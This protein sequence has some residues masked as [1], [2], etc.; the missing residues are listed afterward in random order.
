MGGGRV[1]IHAWI[2]VGVPSAASLGRPSF[3]WASPTRCCLQAASSRSTCSSTTGGASGLLERLGLRVSRLDC[4]EHAFAPPAD[5]ASRWSWLT[6]FVA[7]RKPRIQCGRD[8]V[9]QRVQIEGLRQQ[10]DLEPLRAI[11]RR[12]MRE[13]GD[14][15]SPVFPINLAALRARWRPEWRDFGFFLAAIATCG[16]TLPLT[17]SRT[18][19]G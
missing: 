9:P 18:L 4:A 10:Q 16:A 15:S 3:R 7:A 19:R 8:G 11:A 14:V 13:R 2:A 6:S 1:V 12:I 17:S 5:R